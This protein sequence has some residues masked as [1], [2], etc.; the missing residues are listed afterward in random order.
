M[1]EIIDLLEQADKK[2]Q[3]IIR[4]TPRLICIGKPPEERFAKARNLLQMAITNILMGKG[5]LK[6]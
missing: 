1:Q 4:T 5:E 6:G 3:T 2:L